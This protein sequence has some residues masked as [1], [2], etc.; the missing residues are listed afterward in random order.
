MARFYGGA[1]RRGSGPRLP[2]C[3]PGKRP[4]RSCFRRPAECAYDT[5]DKEP[6]RLYPRIDTGSDGLHGGAQL[7]DSLGVFQ[8]QRFARSFVRSEPAGVDAR[9]ET[10]DEKG[11]GTV[12]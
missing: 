5:Y 2:T 10:E 12:V 1:A 3:V 7:P 8:G 4:R 6:Y 11:F 9:I